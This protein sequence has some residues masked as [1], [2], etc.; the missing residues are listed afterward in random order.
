MA[1]NVKFLKR[2]LIRWR[3]GSYLPGSAALRGL[4]GPRELQAILLRERTRADRCGEP[5]S[6]LALGVPD[7]RAGR[8]TLV[9]L[10]K[11]LRRRLRATDDVG[12]LD[13]RRIGVVL[14]STPSWGAWTVADDVCLDFPYHIPLPECKV[15]CYPSPRSDGQAGWEDTGAALRGEKGPVHAMETMFVVGLPLWK[16]TMD[17]AGAV[18]GLL[19]LSPLLLIVAA[20]IKLTSAGPVIFAQQRSGLGGRPFTIYKFRTMVA[21]AEE[22]RHRLLA[23]NE[24]QGPV[25]KITDDPRVTPLGRVLRKTSIDEIPQ[26]WNV[27]MGDMSLVGP[28][29]PL[30]AEVQQ[31]EPWQRRRL[32]VTP[33]LTCTWQ[34]SGR[35]LISFVDWM[36]MDIRY[37]GLRSVVQDLKLLVRTVIAVM[38][39][40]GAS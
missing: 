35:S 14:P 4:C 8:D 26:F 27:L 23:M 40:R 36:R 32:T 12:W 28:R 6:L 31:Y 2:L 17:I 7:R 39:H 22:Q 3:R 19:V 11:V 5:L 37:I 9:H 33:G 1:T 18:F 24:Q 10:A 25:F 13:D 29:P 38:S 34:V 20:A 30:P 16:R 15:Y 21:D